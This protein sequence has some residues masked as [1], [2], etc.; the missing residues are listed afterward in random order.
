MNNS[1]PDYNRIFP[2]APIFK[3]I[4]KPLLIPEGYTLWKNKSVFYKLVNDDMLFLVSGQRNHLTSLILTISVA[5][6]P[7]CLDLKAIEFEYEDEGYTIIELLKRFV[8][9]KITEEYLRE[10]F[11]SGRDEESTVNSLN[12]ICDDMSNIILPYM[13]RCMDIEYY[14]NDLIK[15]FDGDIPLCSRE[16]YSI[17]LKLHKYINAIIY[18]DNE[19]LRQNKLMN[20]IKSEIIKYKNGNIDE[21]I[22]RAQKRNNYIDS[23]IK[24]Y[25]QMIIDSENQIKNLHVIRAALISNDYNY[26]DKLVMETEDSSREYI[27]KMLKI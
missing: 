12:L 1:I 23:M 3:K 11:L 18:I 5:T 17:S 10:R 9:D 19:L 4:F 20:G 14:Y 2:F 27:K 22:I 7:Y 13:N 26:L 6:I 25:E 21:I 15:S 24:A 16:I 8:P